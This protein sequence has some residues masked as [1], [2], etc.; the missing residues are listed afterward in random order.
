MENDKRKI[1]LKFLNSSTSDYIHFLGIRFFNGGLKRLLNKIQTDRVFVTVPAAPALGSFIND[2]EYY[3][4]IK[5]SE[6]VLIESSYIELILLILK[7]V[8]IRRI[9][10]FGLMHSLFNDDETLNISKKKTLWVIPNLDE[11]KQIRE[12]M[13]KKIGLIKAIFIWLQIIYLVR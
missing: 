11:E 3:E 1:K 12:L 9:S 5:K 8:R 4:A 6:I 10:G 7:R 13:K 2:N